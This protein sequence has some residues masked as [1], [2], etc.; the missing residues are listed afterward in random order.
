MWYIIAAEIFFFSSS[1]GW[2]FSI[3]FLYLVKAFDMITFLRKSCVLWLRSQQLDRWIE[4]SWPCKH[5][6]PLKEE[7]FRWKIVYRGVVLASHDNSWPLDSVPSSHWRVVDFFYLCWMQPLKRVRLGQDS[8]INIYSILESLQLLD[9]PI[10]SWRNFFFPSRFP[11]NE[12]SWI[13]NDN[14]HPR[15]E[16]AVLK[17]V[18]S[19]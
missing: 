8:P 10:H 1:S 3:H 14:K 4:K 19:V 9:S 7:K 12:E 17:C 16:R 6:H 11:L 5:F 15:S 13:R 18:A 2:I